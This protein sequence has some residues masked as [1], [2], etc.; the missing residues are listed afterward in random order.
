MSMLIIIIERAQYQAKGFVLSN[1]L[2]PKKLQTRTRICQTAWE[3]FIAKG[4][5]S[6]STRDIAKA[7]G[8]ANGTLFSHFANKD[9]LLKVL[10]IA[11]IDNV[12][13]D[14]QRS[15][16][17]QQPKL[18][19]RHYATHLYAFYLQH[20]EFSKTLLQSLIW[21]GQFFDEQIQQFKALLFASAPQ[22]D[23]VRAAAMMDCYFMTLIEGLNQPDPNANAMVRRLSA[24]LALL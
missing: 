14:A 8:I 6:T 12:I 16:N 9:E 1:Q 13:A 23:E 18:K 2:T 24:K 5:E 10:M 21:Q 15:D 17:H 7:A 22:Y 20:V 11:Q 19:M 3:L 4:F